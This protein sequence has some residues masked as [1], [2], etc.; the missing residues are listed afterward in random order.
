LPLK[1]CQEFRG[2]KK[3]TKLA[4]EILK[5]YLKEKRLSEPKHLLE[6]WGVFVTKSMDKTII[7]FGFY[8]ISR[9]TQALVNVNPLADNTDQRQSQNNS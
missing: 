5:E 2:H 9:N 7:G 6:F 3:C 8:M 1:F 4:R